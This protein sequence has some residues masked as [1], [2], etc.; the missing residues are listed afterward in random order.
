MDYRFFFR[1]RVVKILCLQR[2]NTGLLNLDANVTGIDSYREKNLLKTSPW[3]Q[4]CYFSELIFIIQ[5]TV[6]R[7]VT[8]VPRYANTRNIWSMSLN[9]TTETN[10]KVVR[11]CKCVAWETLIPTEKIEI[12]PRSIVTF[13][14]NRNTSILIGC[15]KYGN[16]YGNL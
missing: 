16:D 5:R 11:T 6:L 10:W 2:F 8:F 3:K 9:Y 4:A 15:R 13:Y 1:N 7:H 12:I 14:A